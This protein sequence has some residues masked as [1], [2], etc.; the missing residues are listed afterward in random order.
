MAAIDPEGQFGPF[1][2][3]EPPSTLREDF[4][5]S[6]AN[7]S[8]FTLVTGEAWQDGRLVLVGPASS[9]KSH[10]ARIW[11]R[12]SGCPVIDAVDLAGTKIDALRNDSGIVID[13]AEGIASLVERETLLL[14]LLNRINQNNGKALLVARRPP[15]RWPIRVPDLASRLEAASLARIGSPDDRLLKGMLVKLF[16]DRRVAIPS[17][18]VEYIVPR[19]ERSFKEAVR[20]VDAIDRCSLVDGRKINRRL[21][22][23]V[24]NGMNEQ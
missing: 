17:S 3:D 7:S 22:A 11:A 6:S 20:I 14:H 12:Q 15:A 10:L 2:L 9:G 18:V 24:L 16:A 23:D 5:V 13:D 8:A 21:A 4:L 19:M 1:E